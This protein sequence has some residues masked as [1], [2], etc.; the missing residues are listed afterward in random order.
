MTEDPLSSENDDP[1]E[2]IYPR[3]LSYTL[4]GGSLC[5]LIATALDWWNGEAPSWFRAFGLLVYFTWTLAE[6]TRPIPENA[7]ILDLRP[8]L[9]ELTLS[10]WV[11]VLI[12]AATMTAMSQFGP[13]LTAGTAGWIVY[14]LYRLWHGSF[15]RG[16]AGDQAG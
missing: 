1:V 10:G 7:E 12:F 16:G 4:F 9:N 3:W 15:Y 13:V 8:N 6:V 11:A 5:F 14:G 2:L